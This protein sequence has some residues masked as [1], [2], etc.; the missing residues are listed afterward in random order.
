M[1]A[2]GFDDH[3]LQDPDTGNSGSFPRARSSIPAMVA[4]SGGMTSR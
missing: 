4:S 3:D 1:T 2:S